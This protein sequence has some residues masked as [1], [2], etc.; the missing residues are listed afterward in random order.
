MQSSSVSDHSG[1]DGSDPHFS[2]D[3]LI[4]GAFNFRGSIYKMEDIRYLVSGLRLLYVC[5]GLRRNGDIT[6][7]AH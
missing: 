3:R 2:V 4:N 5:S 1:S 6:D 7:C